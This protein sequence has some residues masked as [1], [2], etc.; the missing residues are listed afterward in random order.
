[1]CSFPPLPG[2]KFAEGIE[3]LQYAFK[4]PGL[5]NIA[6]RGPYMHDGSIRDL[7]GVIRHY[8]GRFVQRPSLS[9]EIF[10]LNLPP[11]STN[12]LVAFLKTLSST[13]DVITIPTLPSEA[14]Q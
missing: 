5:R 12:D 4:T 1:M 14:N 13:D 11:A 8:D 6:E 10:P 7:A 3:P 9:E 2:G